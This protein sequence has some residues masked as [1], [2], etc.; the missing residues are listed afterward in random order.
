MSR[1]KKISP[2]PREEVRETLTWAWEKTIN[3]ITENHIDL[4]ITLKL[5]F[6]TYEYFYEG[7]EYNSILR[8]DLPIYRYISEVY[9][10]LASD[11]LSGISKYQD[12]ALRDTVEGLYWSIDSSFRE[13]YYVK[14]L[15]AGVSHHWSS[16]EIDMK[17]YDSYRKGFDFLTGII[18]DMYDEEEEEL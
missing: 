8:S 1:K 5:I 6:D 4:E 13:G 11:Y 15:P 12:E 7:I 18:E 9:A 2:S 10:F 16:Y 14:R 17:D 3:N